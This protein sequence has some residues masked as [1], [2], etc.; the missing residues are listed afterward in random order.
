M[1]VRADV[2]TRLAAAMRQASTEM[3]EAPVEAE[4]ACHLPSFADGV[5]VIGGVPGVSGAFVA[6]GGGCW[7]ILCGPATGLAMSELMLG[8]AATSVDLSPFSP[9]R[10]G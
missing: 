7:G 3:R 5:P 6:S 8:G 1:E 2:T 4:Q 9:A 10:F